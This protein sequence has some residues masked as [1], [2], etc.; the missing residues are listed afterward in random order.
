MG[1]LEIGRLHETCLAHEVT[2]LLAIQS[3]DSS[4]MKSVCLRCYTEGYPNTSI[5][6]NT[7]ML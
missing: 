4:S 2:F 3:V 1:N 6:H 5:A 7:S